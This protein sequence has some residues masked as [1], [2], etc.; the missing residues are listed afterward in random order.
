MATQHTSNNVA[1]A[2]LETGTMKR[3]VSPGAHR[4]PSAEANGSAGDGG[5]HN[6]K[7]K[8]APRALETNGMDFT[9]SFARNARPGIAVPIRPWYRRRSYFVDGWTEPYLWK[10][11]I[12]EAV[13]SFSTTYLSAQFGGTLANSFSASASSLGTGAV[14][15]IWTAVMLSTLILATAPATGGHINPLITWTTMLCGLCP[16]PRAVLYIV[17]QTAGAALAGG[18]LVGSWGHEKAARLHGGGCF[19]DPAGI[20]TGQ[21]L[22]T[23][24]AC[25]FI[26]LYLSFGVGLDPRQAQMFGPA[27][28]PILVG[29]CFGMVNFVTTG[30]A[31]GYSGATMNPARCFGMA[32]ASGDWS[33]QWVWWVAPA[34][35]GILLALLYNPIPP[36]YAEKKDD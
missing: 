19:Y 22:L 11:A 16:V 32:V 24:I 30:T 17:A 13:A 21:V 4:R 6:S 34:I 1:E 3:D 27:L 35:S 20:S 5:P 8:L 7:D 23:D 28:G 36:G 33:K 10:A 9:G 29:L 15:G 26:L 25:G 18:F 2:H 14:I 12:V 31:P